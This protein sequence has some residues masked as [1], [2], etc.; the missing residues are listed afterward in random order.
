METIEAIKFGRRMNLLLHIQRNIHTFLQ[1]KITLN[2][3][4]YQ[5]F[6]IELDIENSTLAI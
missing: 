2:I 6:A 1:F 4:S 3:D 5:L